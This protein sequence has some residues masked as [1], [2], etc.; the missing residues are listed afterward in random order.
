MSRLLRLVALS[1]TLT[2]L[3]PTGAS[4]AE[5]P[6]E[7]QLLSRLGKAR[8]ERHA[9]TGRVR[10]VAAPAGATLPRHAGVGA[11]TRPEAA[12]RAFLN[13]YGPLFGTLC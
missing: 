5:P 3:L 11:A 9:E 6:S 8:V 1:A 13:E 4:A 12:A 10:L 7:Q 2:L